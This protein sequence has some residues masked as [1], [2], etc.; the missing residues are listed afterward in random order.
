MCRIKPL[1]W[2]LANALIALGITSVAIDR[3]LDGPRAAMA[4]VPSQPS[5]VQVV[6]ADGGYRLLRDGTPY[7][8]KGAGGDGSLE[9]LA[10][11][12]GN[13]VR[14]WGAD[15]VGPIL[16][17]AHQLGLTVTVGIWLGHERHG[18]NYHD[19]NQ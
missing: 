3:A 13:S 5:L 14:T 9:A 2:S 10:A 17:Q 7:F 4:A 15:A 16:D 8:I 6:R 12:G 18:F 1:W 19:A 11:A